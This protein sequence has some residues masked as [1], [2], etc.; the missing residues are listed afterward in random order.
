MNTRKYILV[1][2]SLLIITAFVLSACQPV[3]TTV[4]VI[5]TVEVPV[6]EVEDR[7]KSSRPRKSRSSRPRWSRSRRPLSPPRTRS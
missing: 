3:T 7:S 1:A 4:E 5:K 6:E 2:F